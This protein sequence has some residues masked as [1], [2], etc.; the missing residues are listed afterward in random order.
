MSPEATIVWAIAIIAL[1]LVLFFLE[2]LLPSGGLLG[3]LAGGGLVVGIG[4]LFYADTTT[5]I[6]GTIIALVALPFVL[7]FGLKI[8]PHTP[9]FR[10]ITLH[11]QQ[12]AR[13]PLGRDADGTVP[14]VRPG[15]RGRAIT[16]LRPVGTCQVGNRRIE[17]LA[18]HGV[19]AAGHD[20]RV[21]SVDGMQTKV[22]EVQ[23][24]R[25]G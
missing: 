13:S 18:S 22:E 12:P 6:L 9:I 2:V 21:V 11:N 14:E 23:E 7:G 10:A 15:D 24:K 19:I 25:Q 5:G 16:E 20:I 3:V 1:A 17:C 4:M 8:L